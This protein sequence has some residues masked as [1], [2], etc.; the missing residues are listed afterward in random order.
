[1]IEDE[2]TEFKREYISDIKREV[3]AFANTKG[4]KI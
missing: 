4:G 1:M 3:V 2:F